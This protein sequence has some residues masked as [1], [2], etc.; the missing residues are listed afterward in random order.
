[1]RS[2]AMKKICSILEKKDVPLREYRALEFYART[3]DW[4]TTAYAP[5]VKSITAWEIDPK[6][7]AAL[8]RNLPQAKIEIGNSYELANQAEYNEAFEFIVFDNPQGVFGDK[9]YCEHF[10]ALPLVTKLLGKTGIVIFNVNRE[11]FDYDKSPEWKKNRDAFYK[12]ESTSILTSEWLLNFY[13]T[14]FKEMGLIVRLQWHEPRHD[15]YLGY[16]VYY[17]ERN[18]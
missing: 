2:E 7:K 17:L 10:E 18:S 15:A 9:N 8:R 6:F 5:S 11:P 1:M 4:Q 3:G 14:Y 12:T 13:D 16:L